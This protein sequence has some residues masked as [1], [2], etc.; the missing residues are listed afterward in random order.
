MPEKSIDESVLQ[1]L[2]ASD[3]VELRQLPKTVA[4]TF[5]GLQQNSK[6]VLGKDP[7]YAD[8]LT[9]FG[10]R[11]SQLPTGLVLELWKTFLYHLEVDVKPDLKTTKAKNMLALTDQLMSTFLDYACVVEQALPQ[12]IMDKIV[13]L[14]VKTHSDISSVVGH[15]PRVSTSLIELSILLKSCRQIEMSVLTENLKENKKEH[16]L[17]KRK[18]QSLE[19]SNDEGESK[20]KLNCQDILPGN[21]KYLPLIIDELHEADVTEGAKLFLEN[22]EL[23]FQSTR[24]ISEDQRLQIA[25]V[26]SALE[27]T[28]KS[29]VNKNPSKSFVGALMTDRLSWFQS[30]GN[31]SKLTSAAEALKELMIAGKAT[32][33]GGNHAEIIKLLKV[34]PLECLR[35]EFESL[36]SLITVW[37]LMVVPK[38]E[39]STSGSCGLQNHFKKFSALR[40]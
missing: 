15:L 2:L 5:I 38:Q 14:I 6:Q 1:P 4:R 29:F 7:L 37:M 9:T 8:F 31:E 40:L 34:L 11:V 26:I 36:V 33:K 21:I 39:H 30:S 28:Q 17:L 25:L 22:E 16:K 24:I 3:R 19:T 23:L 18:L 27:K 13:E 35:G 32:D 10:T 20:T 12:R